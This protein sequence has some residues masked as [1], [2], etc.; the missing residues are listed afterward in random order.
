MRRKLEAVNDALRPDA[1]F[2]DFFFGRTP[3]TNPLDAVAWAI[4]YI[5]GN[6]TE[7]TACPLRTNPPLSPVSPRRGHGGRRRLDLKRA[8][9][10]RLHRRGFP[11][12]MHIS[13]DPQLAPPVLLLHGR[14]RHRVPSTGTAPARARWIGERAADRDSMELPVHVPGV[15][16]RCLL[17][18]TTTR[19]A[20][21]T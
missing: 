10:D 6:T 18:H 12:V 1:W 21:A 15:L 16:P 3:P 11:V 2:F 5:G 8:E 9:I 20:T 13:N 7:P 14:E 19:R 17:W 4:A